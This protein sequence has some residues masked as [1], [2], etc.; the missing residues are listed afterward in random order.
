M[1]SSQFLKKLRVPPF[2]LWFSAEI[3]CPKTTV[4]LASPPLPPKS[5]TAP[6]PTAPVSSTT[7]ASSGE[8]I[9]ATPRINKF[10]AASSKEVAGANGNNVTAYGVAQCVETIDEKG[11]E[12]C[13]KVAYGNIQR[14]PPE[15]DG[16][17]VDTGCFLRYSELPFFGANYT[18]DLKPYLKSKDSTKKKALIGGLVGGGG[19]LL[20]L[21]IFFVWF[22]V[23]RKDKAVLQDDVEGA[24]E[25]QGPMTYT[26]KELTSATTNFSEENKLGEGGFGAVYKG[27]LKNGRV[28]AVKKLA[29]SKS[30]RVKTEFNTEVKL[31]SN[32][33]HRNLVRLI[34]CCSKGPELLLVYELMANGSLDKHLFGE[35][36]G[37]LNWKQRFDIILGTAKGLAYLHEEFHVCIIHRDIKPGNILLN[38]D[39]QPKIAD[40][41]LVRLLPEDQTH[42][43]TKFAGTLGYT[44]PEY[45]L[46]GQ[47]SEKVDTYS[48][49]V[50]LLEIISGQKNTETSLDPTAEYLLKRAWG[51]YQDNMAMEI[52]DKSLDPSEYNKEDMKRIIEIAFLCTQSSAALRP[53]M[54]EVVALLK[55]LSSLEPRQPTRP[56]FIDSERRIVT[57][58]NRSTS[59]G[60]NATNS[61]TQVSEAMEELKNGYVSPSS[62]PPT[63]PSPLPISVGP[64]NQK[65]FFSPSPS[66]S[67]PFSPSPSNHASAENLPLLHH[68]NRPSAPLKQVTS[69]FSL[70]RKDPDELEDKSSSCLKDFAVAW[71]GKLNAIAC[72]SKTCA[73]IPSSNVNPQFWIPIH[74]VVPERPTEFAVFN[75]IAESE[76]DKVQAPGR[77]K[78]PRALVSESWQASG[79]M[80]SSIDPEAM[81]VDRALVQS[82]QAYVDAVLDLA[83]H[84]RCYARI[85]SSTIVP[86]L[87]IPGLNAPI[88]YAAGFV[89]HPVG[90]GKSPVDEYF[91]ER[92]FYWKI[93]RGVTDPKELEVLDLGYK[94]FSRP[95]P[96]ELGSNLSLMIFWLDFLPFGAF[97]VK[98]SLLLLSLCSSLSLF[99]SVLVK[100]RGMLK[101]EAATLNGISCGNEERGMI[102]IGAATSN[103]LWSTSVSSCVSCP[104]ASQSVAVLRASLLRAVVLLVYLRVCRVREPRSRWPF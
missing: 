60:S 30:E 99:L 95:I 94:N 82:I 50:V 56:A 91:A 54:S 71:Y 64:G 101:M 43:S 26:Y 14:C 73:R 52:V 67:P 70:D 9:E 55:T 40:F 58:D 57:E 78:R 24:P 12:E 81:A 59:S 100:E 44:A 66:P 63:P 6:P 28:V 10:F 32:V 80:L 69:A 72:A 1:S 61:I 85:W 45:A 15:A 75:V 39:L 23:F 84:L 103:G 34:G 16:R 17:A 19:L 22:K 96:P 92:F 65:Y 8:L 83:S 20:L 25:L 88:L 3:T 29:I 18:I 41:G 38:K 42:V 21:S 4:S 35:G 5:A 37:S 7:A 53:T 68:Y 79:E 86:H 47:L 104:R 97:S 102:E 46:H 90:W 49:G 93:P 89:Y 33:H 2:I 77:Y 36:H 98:F 31:I 74:I 87:R 27:V 11:C 51:L 13:L 62:S 48:Y 76:Q